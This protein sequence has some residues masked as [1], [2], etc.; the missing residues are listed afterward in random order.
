[1]FLVREEDLTKANHN[2][3]EFKEKW[4]DYAFLRQLERY[5]TVDMKPRWMFA[6]R[7]DISYGCMNTNNLIE[8]YHN[9]IRRH[10]LA[11]SRR[12]YA[13][14]VIYILYRQ[15]LPSYELKC[16]T[17]DSGAGRMFSGSRKAVELTSVKHLEFDNQQ[18]QVDWNPGFVPPGRVARPAP[19]IFTLEDVNGMKE[20]L[21]KV[22]SV[23]MSLEPKDYQLTCSRL[24]ATILMIEQDQKIE[25][26]GGGKKANGVER[27]QSK[28]HRYN[29]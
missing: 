15:V 17:S 12:R 21:K 22:V 10:Y 7:K 25:Q 18:R 13:D 28:R 14:N 5:F 29:K 3:D 16:V 1:M 6:H 27:Y 20:E 26:E 23:T 11:D 19:K 9:Q 8:S 24:Q 4:K 2:I